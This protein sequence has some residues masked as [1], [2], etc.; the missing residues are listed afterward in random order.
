MATDDGSIRFG[1]DA[2]HRDFGSPLS[3][4]QRGLVERRLD[5]SAN[6]NDAFDDLVGASTPR[7]AAW[8]RS[9]AALADGTSPG[10]PVM[11]AATLGS[12]LA[13]RISTIRTPDDMHGGVRDR[14]WRAVRTGLLR[15]SAGA[16]DREIALRLGC[17]ESGAH[18]RVRAF[19]ELVA[20]SHPIIDIAVD[21]L[22]DAV[23]TD[24]PDGRRSLALVQSESAR[25][26]TAATFTD[27]V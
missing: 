15:A 2:S 23:E 8:M 22:V 11:D 6:A 19:G 14:D 17:S 25:V 20:R 12:A 24:R 26:P 7:V 18:G 5:V 27:T 21:S 1:P 13:A 3:D 10:V 9:Q 4:T 16:T